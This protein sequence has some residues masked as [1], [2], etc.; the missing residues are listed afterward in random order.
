MLGIEHVASYLPEARRENIQ[1]ARRFDVDPAFLRD[2][3]GVLQRARKAPNE[4]TSDLARLA[5]ERLFRETSVDPHAID[6]LVVVTQ[7]PDFPIPHVSAIVHG[8]LRLPDRCAAFDVSLGCSGFVYGLSVLQSFLA[9][10]GLSR[11]LLVTADPY[12]KIVDENDKGTALLFGDAA[13][14]TLIGPDALYVA[15]PFT[16]GTHGALHQALICRD[17]VLKMNGRDV[18]NFTA[19]AVPGDLAALLDKAGLAVEDVDCFLLHQGSKFI[20]ETIARRAG[21]PMEKVR[22]GLENIGNTVSSSIPLLLEQE[23]KNAQTSTLVLSGFGVG[24][25]WASC[26]LRRTR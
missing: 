1:D 13:S 4:N 23:V 5:C 12:S 18:F 8:S 26:V 24:L 19:T 20:V 6:A 11:G 15:A 21:L 16:F 7:S 9:A 17:G 14:A 10:N 22:L 3:L 25:S 2:K